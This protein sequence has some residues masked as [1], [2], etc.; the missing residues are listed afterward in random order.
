MGREFNGKSKALLQRVIF[1][2][3]HCSRSERVPPLP[4][5]PREATISRVSPGGCEAPGEAVKPAVAYCMILF[6]G[7]VVTKCETMLCMLTIA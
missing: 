2:S 4:F 1:Y 3:E 7:W 6:M 5:P